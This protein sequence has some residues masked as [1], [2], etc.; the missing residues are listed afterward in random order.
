[1]ATVTHPSKEQVRQ[2]QKQRWAERKPVPTPEQIRTELGW[3]MIKGAARA[4]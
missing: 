2:W 4:R 3:N 1:M